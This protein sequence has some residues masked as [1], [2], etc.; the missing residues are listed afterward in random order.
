MSVEHITRLEAELRFARADNARLV[1]ANKVLGA[2]LEVVIA[3]R[4]L[5]ATPCARCQERDAC[6]QAERQARTP[7][8]NDRANLLLARHLGRP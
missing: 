8:D 1:D 4:D 7:Y 3:E 6:D 5:L 2:R